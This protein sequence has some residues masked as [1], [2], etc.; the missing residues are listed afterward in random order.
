MSEKEYIEKYK[1]DAIKEM[2]VHGIPAS[3]IIAQGMLESGNGNSALA[4]YANNHFGI[5]CHKG[6]NGSTFIH[7][8]DEKN[9][10]FRKYPN[11]FDS[12]NDHS[13]F[14]KSRPWYI[15]LFQLRTTDYR[16]WAKGLKASGYATDPKYAERLIDII[17]E[18]KLYQ[19]DYVAELPN[20]TAQ[21]N[22]H[23]T[24]DIIKS[25]NNK[26]L[27]NGLRY[28]IIRDGE[29]F[30]KI[31]VESDIELADL[32][33][34]N[35]LSKGDRATSGQIIYLE[36]KKR[37]GVDDYHIVREGETIKTIAQLYG[38]KLKVLRKKNRIKSDEDLK[39]GDTLCLKKC[40]K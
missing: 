8:D 32:Y 15:P 22:N 23:K 5:K 13:L 34:Y 28:T 12:Y 11:V 1:E 30:Y 17:E 4:V 21:L 25:R 18:Y 24:S 14:L 20:L 10:C 31:A 6:W 36:P 29:S 9:E 40:R 7:D 38:I 3:I 35:D 2:L 16:S 37:T 33:T 27:F 26:I 39:A 19:Y